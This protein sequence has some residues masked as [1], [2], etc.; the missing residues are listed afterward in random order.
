MP[1]IFEKSRKKFRSFE[2]L[3]MISKIFVTIC[4]FFV[5]LPLHCRE[6]RPVVPFSN[7]GTQFAT[8]R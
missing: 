1:Q 8:M 3:T 6:L 7:C 5:F 4:Q 2:I